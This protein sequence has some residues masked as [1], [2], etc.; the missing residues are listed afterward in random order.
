MKVERHQS[1]GSSC[2]SKP[3]R[4]W[5][6]IWLKQIK[7]ERKEITADVPKS[8]LNSS[9]PKT[10]QKTQKNDSFQMHILLRL[11]ITTKGWVGKGK[12]ICFSIAFL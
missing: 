9:L 8:Q 10:G 11:V 12:D 3:G 6:S 4:A 2:L 1:Q 7:S 5:V